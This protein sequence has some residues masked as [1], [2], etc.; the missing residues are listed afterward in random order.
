MRASSDGKPIEE[1]RRL[2][3]NFLREAWE[4]LRIEHVVP[5]SLFRPH[6]HVGTDYE[7]QPLMGLASFNS[8]EAALFAHFPNRFEEPLR[9]DKPEFPSHYIFR[10]L[11]AYIAHSAKFG[12]DA[13]GASTLST[14]VNEFLA[15]LSADEYTLVSARVISHVTT[16][17]MEPIEIDGLVVQPLRQPSF[18]DPPMAAI[19]RLIPD[20][21]R[22]F[23]DDPPFA[24]DPPTS[25]VIAK[26][27]SKE[28]SE[29]VAARLARRIER[30]L[31][32]T[33]LIHG[34]TT[35]SHWQITGPTTLISEAS[36]HGSG[37]VES[38]F[39]FQFVQRIATI[40]TVDAAAYSA[41]DKLLDNAVIAREKMVTTSFDMGLNRFTRTYT[42][43]DLLDAFV[44]L[45]T[46]M[47]AIFV[48][49]GNSNEDVGL[50]LRTRAAA[51]LAT[52][53]DSGRKIFDDVRRLYNIRSKLVHGGSLTMKDLDKDLK[54][55]VPGYNGVASAVAMTFAVDRFRDLARRAILARLA[56][57]SGETPLWPWVGDTQVDAELADDRARQHWRNS[58]TTQL[59][60][61]GLSK[62]VGKAEP[63]VDVLAPAPLGKPAEATSADPS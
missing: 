59:S 50:R 56:L 38:G 13:E 30:F 49:G 58:W 9:A 55:L 34:A 46:T 22:A 57:A 33:R 21:S 61:L 14:V 52:S 63:A 62:S 53:E 18:E 16:A 11:E 5:A 39:A 19:S 42:S 1:I 6:L 26:E 27:T 32:I 24:Y 25:I 4:C 40:S 31:L 20:A 23:A 3:V 47:E 48:S 37:F 45:A 44:D 8:L 41:L 7:G 54:N 36:I 17:T 60:V 10:L 28:A 12:D 29:S 43:G 15:A 2:A 51:L 35:Q